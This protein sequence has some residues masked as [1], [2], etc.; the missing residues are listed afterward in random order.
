MKLDQPIPVTILT[1]FLGSGKSTLLNELLAN[2][3]FA[4]TAVIINEFGDISIDHDLV[5]VNKRE[6]MVTTTGCLCCTAASDIRSSLFDLYDA[7]EGKAVP[8]FKRV[9]VET[10][11]LA[12]PAPIINQITSGGL[13]AVGYRDHVVARCFRL[14][15]V[16]CTVDVTM[17]EETMER[18][19]ECMKQVAFADRVVLTKTDVDAEAA[20]APALSRLLS[21][22]RQI[23][24]AASVVDRH[25][26]EF[27]LAALFASRRYV[28]SEQG[29]DVEGWLALE[30]ALAQQ[31]QVHGNSAGVSSRH[32]AAGIQSMALLESRPVS[33]RNLA[34]FVDLLK[35]VG[36]PQLLR[37]KGIVA[38]DDDPER[39]LVVHGVQHAIQQY[40][41]ATWP[42]EDRRTRMVVI[43]HG[44]DEAVVRTLFTAITGVSTRQ[45]AELILTAGAVSVL[46]F[47]L[48]GGLLLFLGHATAEIQPQPAI[49]N[50]ARLQH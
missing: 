16:V 6:L 2:E 5:R 42:S 33:P 23:N 17:I 45:K 47:A 18:H 25:G 44:L 19:F 20:A 30:A 43:A 22:M 39:P 37:L 36:G 46:G 8:P 28:P 7:L 26:K 29:G 9:I 3:A 12:D 1:G 10:T 32:A 34:T 11:G 21:K 31:G 38:L 41:L 24:A 35:A 14:S 48:V 40:R 27:D 49:P 13:P 15:G 4:D 50:A